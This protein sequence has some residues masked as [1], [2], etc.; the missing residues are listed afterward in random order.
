MLLM[1]HLLMSVSEMWQKKAK[2]QFRLNSC[3]SFKIKSTWKVVDD[4]IPLNIQFSLQFFLLQYFF[5]SSKT[6]FNVFQAAFPSFP[7]NFSPQTPNILVV[8]FWPWNNH[9]S[10]SSEAHKLF[11]WH[12]PSCFFSLCSPGLAIIDQ[13]KKAEM[14]AGTTH[15]SRQIYQR[16][17]VN[18]V[19][20]G[21]WSEKMS[22]WH[23][24]FQ[25]KD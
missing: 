21:R 12:W 22:K 23:A 16:L 8:A 2:H 17:A 11:F 6:Y 18:E 13:I 15:F 1:A 9:Y 19:T 10:S 5:T 14:P 24:G 25:L 7:C 3:R 20:P 4:N